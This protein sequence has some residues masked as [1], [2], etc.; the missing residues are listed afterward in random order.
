T[1][2]KFYC[3]GREPT[4]KSLNSTRQKTFLDPPIYGPRSC[5]PEAWLA[6]PS[7][8]AREGERSSSA[9]RGIG[10]DRAGDSDHPSLA[11]EGRQDHTHR[12]NQESD[13]ASRSDARK[14]GERKKLGSAEHGI[15]PMP[16]AV[17]HHPTTG[18]ANGR[19]ESETIVT[20]QRTYPA[21]TER[22]VD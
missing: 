17:T 18:H 5:G 9:V 1:K 12:Y 22:E 19:H 11:W 20:K 16:Q 15:P 8:G 13:G 21:T 4:L 10:I 2:K 14:I 6:E 7:E 3:L